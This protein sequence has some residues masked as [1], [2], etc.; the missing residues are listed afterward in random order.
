M[1]EVVEGEI[2]HL[3][4][5]S[6]EEYVTLLEDFF[7]SGDHKNDLAAIDGVANKP[8]YVS[9]N[10]V[11]KGLIG[12]DCCVHFTESIF[13][14]ARSNMH[15]VLGGVIPA[16]NQFGEPVCLLKRSMMKSYYHNYDAINCKPDKRVFSLYDTVVL[17]NVTE[18]AFI[19]LRD[20]LQD[21]NGRI[22]CIGSAWNDF[23]CFFSDRSN[24]VYI[25]ELNDSMREIVGEKTMYLAEF[26]SNMAEWQERCN[27]GSFSYDEIMSL[28][29]FFSIRKTNG[30]EYPDKKYY[31]VN[32]A[33]P[34]EGLMSICDKVQSPYGYAEANG[35]IPVIRLTS[36]FQSIYSD[37]QGED[38]WDKFFMQ[39]YGENALEWKNAKNVWESPY[40]CVSFPAR[41]LMRKI[42]EC[43]AA[44]F[45]NTFLIND[46]VKEE[47]DRVR[48]SV[49]PNPQRTIGVLIRGTDY[50]V[51]R[52]PGHPRMASPQ[53]VFEKIKEFEHSGDYDEIFLSTE[54]EDVLQTM[55]GLCGDRLHYIDQK[56]FR[57]RPGELLADQAK[58]RE[59]EGWLKGKEYL[60]TLQLLSECAAFIASG[61]CCGT[62]CVMNTGGNH[63]K[64][65]YIFNLG[66]D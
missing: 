5:D 23:R 61:G 29:Y 57:I 41:W 63:F 19:L 33:F 6:P 2:Y 47:I 24:I 8:I 48:T 25:N 16:I 17:I 66:I 37:F 27:M 21:Y 56:R 46:R 14:D 3:Y 22:I 4:A 15:L 18:H 59:N 12:D 50:T 34:M 55:K 36:S 49:L 31:L 51:S 35:F 39:P 40:C 10:D 60:T 1:I 45:M 43:K 65:T 11:K 26:T 42:S 20:A 64:E 28:V 9:E 32:I 38:I 54:D 13:K 62:T 58:E 7:S 52:L 53:Q 30:S 44:H